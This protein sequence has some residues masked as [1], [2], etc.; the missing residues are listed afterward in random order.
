V[1]AW[2][3]PLLLRGL[4]KDPARRFPSLAELVVELARD[5][6]A[7]RARRRRLA[8]QLLATAAMTVLMIVGGI[9]LYGVLVE[10]AAERRADARLEQLHEQWASARA[11]GDTAK[12]DRLLAAFVEF[13]DNR[14]TAAVSRAYREYAAELTDPAAAVDAFAGAYLTATDRDDEISALRGLIPRLVAAGRHLEAGAALAT[15]DRRAPELAADPELTL[16]R[17]AAALRS[18]DLP[19]AAAALAMLAPD[20]PTRAY[21]QVLENLFRATAITVEQFEGGPVRMGLDAADLD[22][23]GR[24]EVA[25]LAAQGPGFF[26]LTTG[27]GGLSSLG[28]IRGG[29][30]DPKISLLPHTLAGA[31][32]AILVGPGDGLAIDRSHRLVELLADGGTVTRLAWPDSKLRAPVVTDLDGDGTPEIYIGSGAY[33]R[34]LSRI[35]RGPG[36]SWRRRSV[37]PEIDRIASDINPLVAGDLDGDGRDELVVALGAWRAFDVRVLRG[38]PD[39]AIDQVARKTTGFV[40]A[41]GLVRVGDETWIAALKRDENASAARFSPTAP[42]GPPAGIYLFALRDDALVEVGFVPSRPPELESFLQPLLVTDLDGDGHDDL[43]ATA[44]AS[45]DVEVHLA[46]LRQHAGG[47]LPPLLIR[48]LEPQLLVEVDGDPARELIVGGERLRPTEHFVLGLGDAP[49][50]PL[51][52]TRSEPRPLPAAVDDPTLAAAWR[53]AEEMVAVGLTH[54]SAVELAGLA[55]LAGHVRED[56]LLR[57]GELEALAGD[58][59]GAAERFIAAAERPDLADQAL[60]G[61]IRSRRALGEVDAEAALVARRAALPGLSPDDRRAAQA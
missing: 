19:T 43:V 27:A 39:G 30:G 35:D 12:A 1:P 26:A 2:I 54:R 49:L 6:E 40:S 42:Y 38:G 5:P 60:A 7:E 61:A 53:H 36:G 9:R 21:G 51:P 46:V 45:G 14:G 50:P 17:S 44:L 48:G 22:G 34:R 13:P 23:D 41:L 10:R 47:F 57:A 52:V 37:H 56:L 16:A 55:G 59:K 33:A 11:Q 58:H 15:L 32:M 3:G 31:P 29:P 20:D 8:L 4:A 28:V 24:S 25:T 18:R